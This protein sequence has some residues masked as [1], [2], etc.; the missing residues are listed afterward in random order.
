VADAG[1]V[2]EN[3]GDLDATVSSL[4]ATCSTVSRCRPASQLTVL[5]SL[6]LAKNVLTLTGQAVRRLARGDF[7]QCGSNRSSAR[8]WTCRGPVRR[9]VQGPTA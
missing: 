1:A 5:P 2:N 7:S 3:L 8:Q 9:S 4:W 6:L